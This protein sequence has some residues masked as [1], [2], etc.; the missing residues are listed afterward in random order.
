MKKIN[1]EPSLT[2]QSN[3]A[4]QTPVGLTPS[5]RLRQNKL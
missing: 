3:D 4:Y 2:C 5:D 1:L